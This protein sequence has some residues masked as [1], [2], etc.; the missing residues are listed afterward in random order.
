MARTITPTQKLG[1]EVHEGR[2]FLVRTLE[3]APTPTREHHLRTVFGS[4]SRRQDS[5]MGSRWAPSSARYP[6]GDD[7]APVTHRM[8]A[9]TLFAHTIGSSELRRIAEEVEAMVA[10]T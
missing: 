6:I 2:T 10:T 4:P 8:D 7:N 5:H 9:R 3:P 1:I